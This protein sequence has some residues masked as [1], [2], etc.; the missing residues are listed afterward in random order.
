M[1]VVRKYSLTITLLSPFHFPTEDF[2]AFGYDSL[3]HRDSSGKPLIPREQIRGLLRHGIEALAQVGNADAKKVLPDL[4]RAGANSSPAPRSEEAA[5]DAKSDYDQHTKGLVSVTDAIGDWLSKEAIAPA[6]RVALDTVSGA[7]KPGQLQLIEQLALPGQTVDFACSIYFYQK[8]GSDFSEL[9]SNA[10]RFHSAVGAQKSVGFGRILDAKA[11]IESVAQAFAGLPNAEIETRDQLNWYFNL[12]RPYLVN[13][14]KLSENAYRGQ[15]DIPGGA[16]KGLLAQH[17]V[18]TT[19][20]LSSEMSAALSAL[21]IGFAAPVGAKLEVP[22]SVV[23]D[24]ET[25]SELDLANASSIVSEAGTLERQADWKGSTAE[26]DQFENRVH[27]AID[28]DRGSAVEH[29]LFT[30]HARFPSRDGFVASLD[31]AK[32]SE[33]QR[34]TLVG[35]MSEMMVGLGRT[36]A[37]VCTT[38][39]L[40]VP[41][42]AFHLERGP[43]AIV[44]ESPGLLVEPMPN[45]TAFEAYRN[46]WREW[47]PNSDL[48][49]SYTKERLAGG[50]QAMRFGRRDDYSTFVLTEAA[51]VFVLDLNQADIA[52]LQGLL[53]FGVCR[54]VWA[55]QKTTWQ[56]CP[57][58]AQ[59]GYGSLRL[60]PMPSGGVHQ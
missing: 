25:K 39:L 49:K 55:G 30:L 13:S 56:N 18:T 51:S 23:R 38:G 8:P 26:H 1:R 2:G 3:S 5:S 29:K 43:I 44:L 54:P 45:E 20:D 48:L 31:F 57:F 35:A 60:H 28:A 9:L 7:A 41:D 53:R 4:G 33:S 32:V 37:V 27:V 52:V 59:N 12:D 34:P 47:L 58:V 50:Y 19:G 14:E 24:T 10:I 22:R 36:D 16:L 46:A 6:P 42:D 15:C 40:G 21:R 11:G 17:L